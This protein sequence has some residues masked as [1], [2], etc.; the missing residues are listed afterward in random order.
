MAGDELALRE[1]IRGRAADVLVDPRQLQIGGDVPPDDPHV[2]V[3]D[4]QAHGG[5]GRQPLQHRQLRL[6]AAQRVQVGRDHDG[7]GGAAVRERA[8]GHCR[9][10][11]PSV[12]AAQVQDGAA[13]PVPLAELAEGGQPLPRG[14]REQ[15]GSRL[16]EHVLGGMPEQALGRGSPSGNAAFGV[17]YRGGGLGEVQ[18]TVE[19]DVGGMRKT[20]HGTASLRAHS[21]SRAGRRTTTARAGAA[22]HR[23]GGNLPCNE[24]HRPP[25]SEGRRHAGP[26]SRSSSTAATAPARS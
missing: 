7:R 10:Q 23:G 9:A 1:E 12:P 19:I 16:P 15:P 20:I 13:G 22:S 4:R 21:A 8:E 25:W 14:R 6:P 3:E 24:L 2:G 5:L 18:R 26:I 11:G 17:Q